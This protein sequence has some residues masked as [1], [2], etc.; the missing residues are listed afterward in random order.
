[1]AV[2]TARTR[3][4]KKTGELEYKNEYQTIDISKDRKETRKAIG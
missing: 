2:Y 1:M 4:V 3:G